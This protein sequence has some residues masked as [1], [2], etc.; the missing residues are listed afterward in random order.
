MLLNLDV[1]Y[2]Y[3]HPKYVA[4]AT[5]YAKIDIRGAWESCVYL[6]VRVCVCI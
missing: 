2:I 6:C 5:Y 3:E 1:L 4:Q